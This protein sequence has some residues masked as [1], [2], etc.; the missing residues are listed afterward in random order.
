MKQFIITALCLLC[1][2]I[3]AQAQYMPADIIAKA[4]SVL[5]DAVGK[6]I[7]TMYY[8]RW[9]TNLYEYKSKKNSKKLKSGFLSET[10]KRVSNEPTKG[11][12]CKAGVWYNVHLGVPKCLSADVWV[13]FDSTLSVIASVDTAVIPKYIREGKPCNFISKER[14]A[15]LAEAF[16]NEKGYGTAIEK[17]EANY[18]T[19]RFHAYY[20]VANRKIWEA[21]EP[22]GKP[23]GE[24]EQAYID[25]VTGMPKEYN[26]YEFG[27]IP[28]ME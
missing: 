19:Y 4:D 12:F 13:E 20:W 11:I 5:I 18:I 15:E 8:V 16:F 27:T 21:Q 10:G 22:G 7:F 6:D 24:M 17:V 2:C 28:M 23:Y 25:A 1:L 26:I 3:P 14:A 9:G